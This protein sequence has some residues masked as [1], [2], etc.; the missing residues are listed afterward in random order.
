MESRETR[1]YV[2]LSFITAIVCIVL[3]G[4]VYQ[5][6]TNEST[7]VYNSMQQ[8][9]DG[10]AKKDYGYIDLSL[11][12]IRNENIFFIIYQIFQTYYGID[13]VIV[14]SHSIKG[15]FTYGRSHE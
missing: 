11:I 5:A 1:M 10:S 6:H 12:R 3:E 7:S 2:A 13:S 15:T 14:F 4:M 9:N 8:L